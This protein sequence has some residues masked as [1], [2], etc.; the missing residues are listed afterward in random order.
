[1]AA[2]R[3]GRASSTMLSSV[4]LQ[5]LLCLSGAYDALYFLAT[6]LLII[7]KSQVFTYPYP[8]L[9]LD[10]SLLLLTGILEVAR[11]YL[12]GPTGVQASG[13]LCLPRRRRPPSGAPQRAPTVCR[14]TRTGRAGGDQ[15]LAPRPC[16]PPGHSS[17]SRP[18]AP[19][20]PTPTSEDAGTRP[21]HP[22]STAGACGHH[23]RGRAHTPGAAGGAGHRLPSSSRGSAFPVTDPFVESPV[24]FYGCA[25]RTPELPLAQRKIFLE[26][27]F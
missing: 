16:T 10:L 2:A 20:M 9:V 19:A 22:R 15:Q 13:P 21:C 26:I 5:M 14:S 1:M 25:Q 3:R 27:F 18:P 11:L 6:L 7:Y 23:W 24:V 4:S 17:M 12:E 8:H